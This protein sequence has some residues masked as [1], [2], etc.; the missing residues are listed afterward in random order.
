MEWIYYDA[1]SLDGSLHLQR[2]CVEGVA[3]VDCVQDLDHAEEHVGDEGCVGYVVRVEYV[4]C[5]MRVV[6]GDCEGRLG[7]AMHVVCVGYLRWGYGMDEVAWRQEGGQRGNLHNGYG[8]VWEKDG[9]TVRE[10]MTNEEGKAVEAVEVL[11]AL[12]HISPC[13]SSILYLFRKIP[14]TDLSGSKGKDNTKTRKTSG[15]NTN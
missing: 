15:T 13:A 8:E 2:L 7:R 14:R 9:K 3:Y 10:G 6:G 12:F 5:V 1:R 11:G 4:G